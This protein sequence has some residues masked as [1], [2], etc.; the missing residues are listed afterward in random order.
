MSSGSPVWARPNVQ[1]VRQSVYDVP[2]RPTAVATMLCAFGKVVRQRAYDVPQSPTAVA[3]MLCVAGKDVRQSMYDSSQAAASVASDIEAAA[4]A[5]QAS[6]EISHQPGVLD[7]HNAGGHD[8]Y[9]GSS[10]PASEPALDADSWQDPRGHLVSAHD[11]DHSE[12]P[13][14]LPSRPASASHQQ[15]AHDSD[16]DRSSRSMYSQSA[17]ASHQQ[18]APDTGYS[19]SSR[20]LPSQPASASHQQQAPDTDN[21]RSSRLLD[22]QRVSSAS[23]QQRARSHPTAVA[24]SYASQNAGDGW[25]VNSPVTHGLDRSRPSNDGSLALDGESQSAYTA[26]DYAW[27]QG[28]PEVS[29]PSQQQQH[30]WAS[31]PHDRA[32]SW[33][34]ADPHPTLYKHQHASHW[35]SHQSSQPSHLSSHQVWPPSSQ[36]HGP[37]SGQRLPGHQS[38]RPPASAQV[39]QG[40]RH[41]PEAQSDFQLQQGSLQSGHTSEAGALEEESSAASLGMAHQPPRKLSEVSIC[42]SSSASAPSP[43]ASALPL[44][45]LPFLFCTYPSSPASSLPDL[46]PPFLFCICSS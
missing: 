30:P 41:R 15:Q 18:Q 16:H 8:A 21:S 33:D 6:E 32:S 22:S 27:A 7:S 13:R 1:D 17:T 5:G 2:Q 11:S 38:G 24:T 35:S 10:C 14:S 12:S 44:L 26:E 29:L 31:E 25:D 43:S 37:S 40:Y 28:E 45:H 42:P 20:S 4:S 3:T 39:K 46:Y 19:R 36:Q 9:H 34:Q 23:H